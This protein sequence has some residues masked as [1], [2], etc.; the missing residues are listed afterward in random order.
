MKRHIRRINP[1]IFLVLFLFS[2]SHHIDPKGKNGQGISSPAC[3]IYKTR[4]DYSQH[5]PV[6]LNADRTAIT[7]YPDIKDVYYQ[8][9]FAFPT[10]LSGGFLL[11]NRGIGPNVA[12]LDYTYEE[13]S[14][15]GQTP[16]I[17]QLFSHILEKD[18]LTEMYKCGRRID[19][20]DIENE[21]N[22]LIISGK[23]NSCEK[24]K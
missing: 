8:G 14:K 4:A 23:L 18:P 7:S 22:R 9:K 20:H 5:V 21:L 3:I 1:I 17:D 12:F 13:Y 11:D 16:S 24:I 15:L 6:I 19:Y 10:R 2:C